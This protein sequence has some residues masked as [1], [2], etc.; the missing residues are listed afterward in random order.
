MGCSAGPR[1]Q[2]IEVV[3]LQK[4]L[5]TQLWCGFETMAGKKLSKEKFLA[6]FQ[7]GQQ[8]DPFRLPLSIK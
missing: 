4:T 8:S 1:A 7:P 5:P 6:K 2:K 3:H